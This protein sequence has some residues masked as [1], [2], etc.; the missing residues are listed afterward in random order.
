MGGKNNAV[1]MEVV[2]SMELLKYIARIFTGFVMFLSF[3]HS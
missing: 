2:K 1:T 3:A